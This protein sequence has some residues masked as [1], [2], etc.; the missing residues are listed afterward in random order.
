M[1]FFANIEDYSVNYKE[2]ADLSLRFTPFPNT[3]KK[4]TPV[5]HNYN[6]LAKDTYSDPKFIYNFTGY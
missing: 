5:P 2:L 4:Y 3:D 6:V 1:L